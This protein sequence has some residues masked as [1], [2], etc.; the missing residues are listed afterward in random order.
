MFR[1]RIFYIVLF[2]G[3]PG[4]V[5]S[6]SGTL[7]K[8]T[9]DISDT[10]FIKKVK[11]TRKTKSNLD[12]AHSC[13]YM[14]NNGYKCNAYSFIDGTCSLAKLTYLEDPE[15]DKKYREIFISLGNNPLN[16]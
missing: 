15:P 14:K 11:L 13:L 1:T 12:C 7:Y 3:Y 2:I 8:R 9:K 6:D 10:T 16:Q 4:W 5:S